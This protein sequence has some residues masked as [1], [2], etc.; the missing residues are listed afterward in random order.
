MVLPQILLDPNIILGKFLYSYLYSRDKKLSRR[1]PE[2]Q[3]EEL[4]VDGICGVY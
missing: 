1:N 3:I 2:I 4:A